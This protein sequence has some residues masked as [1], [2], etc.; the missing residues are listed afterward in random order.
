MIPS[1]SQTPKPSR[2]ATIPPTLAEEIEQALEMVRRVKRAQ[3]ARVNKELPE[4]YGNTYVVPKRLIYRVTPLTE[5]Q[6]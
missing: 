6:G 1:D 5:G 2:E 3:D 4:T